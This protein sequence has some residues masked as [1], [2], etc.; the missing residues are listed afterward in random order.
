MKGIILAGGHGTRLQPLTLAISKQLLPVY[1][2]PLIYYPLTT[3]MLAGIRDFLLISTPNHLSLFQSL[4]GNGSELGINIEYATQLNPSG[5][6][7]AFNIAKNFI[8]EEPISLI[9]GDNFFYGPGIGRS[10][11]ESI[12][13]TGAKIFLKEKNFLNFN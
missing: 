8:G 13:P 1:N 10:L 12:N 6:P 11:K 4:L 5:I 9:L 3:L 7:D 2:K